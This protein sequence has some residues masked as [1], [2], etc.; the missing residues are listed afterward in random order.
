MDVVGFGAKVPGLQFRQ[1]WEL[2]APDVVEY[3]PAA[4]LS[5]GP[6][7]PV[8]F[9]NDPGRQGMHE[10]DVVTPIAVEYVPVAQALHMLEPS[11]LENVPSMQSIQLLEEDAL[12]PVEYVPAGH[13]EQTLDDS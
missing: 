13:N 11:M 5:H 9:E 1:F 6:P 8:K 12:D 10:F 3:F 2:K 7:K 4:Q